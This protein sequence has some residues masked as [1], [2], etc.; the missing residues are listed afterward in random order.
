MRERERKEEEER[1]NLV[2][3]GIEGSS[4]QNKF[5]C[6]FLPKGFSKLVALRAPSWP[7]CVIAVLKLAR[8]LRWC[9][10]TVVSPRQ[11]PSAGSNAYP[12]RSLT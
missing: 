8:F 2:G 6:S 9:N 12:C 4:H 10:D 11:E 7:N 1:E 5:F 3:S